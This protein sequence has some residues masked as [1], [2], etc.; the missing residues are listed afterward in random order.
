[1]QYLSKL[2]CLLMLLPVLASCAVSAIHPSLTSGNG[3][4]DLIPV[5]DFVANRDSNFSYRISPDGKKLAWI[6]VKGVSL[7]IHIKNLETNTIRTIPADYWYGGVIWAQ[8]SRH[9]ISNSFVECGTENNLII[10]LDT[11]QT[12][13]NLNKK[14]I[15]PIGGVR[16]ELVQLII[17][18]PEHIL[19]THN[20]R[21]KTIFDL[22]RVNIKTKEQTLIAENPGNVTQWLTNPQGELTGRIVK[23]ANTKTLELYQSVKAVYKPVYQWTLNDTVRVVSINDKGAKIYI[24]SNKGRDHQVLLELASESGKETVLYAD[25]VVDITDIYKHPV[26]GK[27]LIAFSDPDYPRYTLLDQSLSTVFSYFNNKTPAKL[28]I[29]SSDNQLHRVTI[30]LHTDKGGEYYLYDL[31]T[32]TSELLGTYPML[33]YKNILADVTP[34]EILSRD[35]EPLHGYLTLP[36]GVPPHRLPLILLVHGGPW[37]RDFWNYETDE[38]QFFAN[39]GYAVLQINYRGST[40][41]G[42]RFQELAFGEFAGNMHNDLLDGVNW[43]ISKGIADPAK[44]AIVGGSYGGYAAL[45]GLSFTPDVFACGIDINGMSDLASLIKNLPLDWKLEMDN[46]Y[47]YV[48]DPDKEIDRA[49]MREKS[50]LFKT[51][52]ISKPLMIIQG[53]DDVR[54]HKE[55][56]VELVKKLE[57]ANKEVTFWL[58]SGAGH[59]L[60]HWPLRLKLFRKMEDFLARCL[61]GRSSGFDFYQLGSW[62]F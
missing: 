46:W 43:A 37:E 49:I 44:V 19:I 51:D 11:E 35:N 3:L 50:P 10:T 42:R 9:L 2:F 53:A 45:V 38:V 32:N 55:Q 21:D 59:V 13:D 23:Q 40:G 48:G 8:D 26:T 22:Y 54:I 28:T 47:R 20:K 33:E 31:R 25:P 61:G 60:I 4:P 34:I 41:Y 36:K 12:D 52:N 24:L 17:N 5:R 16:S 7:H 15:S 58:V 14:R 18:D 6:A 30:L 62:L 27:P 39:R 57:Q 1:M 56:S 29:S